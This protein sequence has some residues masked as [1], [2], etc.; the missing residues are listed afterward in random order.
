[1]GGDDGIC[2]AQPSISAPETRKACLAKSLRLTCIID[3]GS[4]NFHSYL[5]AKRTING[6]M[7]TKAMDSYWF[8]KSL[9]IEAV[10]NALRRL[11]R[12]RRIYATATRKLLVGEKS[13]LNSST[14]SARTL[15]IPR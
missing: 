14:A 6:G 3:Q 13:L 11:L 12:W 10:A 15:R 1:M 2:L 9:E 4:R 7:V 8:R 5:I